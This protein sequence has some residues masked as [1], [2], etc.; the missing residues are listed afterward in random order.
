MKARTI[1]AGHSVGKVLS[2][3]IFGATRQKLFARGHRIEANDVLRLHSEGIAQVSIAELETGEVDE[4]EAVMQVAR[5]IGSGS[6]EAR[7]VPGGKVNLLATEPCCV[8]V[9]DRLLKEVNFLGCV[10]VATLANFSYAE[11][12]AR[13]SSVKSIPFAVDK[14]RLDR[15]LSLLQDKGPVLQAR[16]I[17]TPAVGILYTDPVSGERAR[18]QFENIMRQRLERMGIRST[19][20]LVTI[21]EEAAVARSLEHLLLA[22]PSSVLIAS[23]TAPASIGDVVGRA[24]LRAGCRIERCLAPVEPGSLFLLGYKDD[25]PIVLAVGC[26]RSAKPNLLDLLL[27][28]ML[29]RHRVSSWDV[30]RLGHGGLLA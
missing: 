18:H 13:I 29:A 27:P 22:K 24:M 11:A 15:V 19:Y 7:L 20:V 4:D 5:E 16:P 12:W 25:I 17:R 9:D 21:E 6:I 26:Y 10:A 28:P 2:D 30:A 1:D 8:L 14:L 3:P 23:T